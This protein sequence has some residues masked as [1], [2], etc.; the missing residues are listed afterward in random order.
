MPQPGDGLEIVAG[1]GF[2]GWSTLNDV[3]MGGRSSGWC[4][5]GSDG[6][7]MEAQVVAEGG[8]FVSCRSP[9]FVPPLD[10]SAYRGLALELDGDGRR[11]KLAIACADRVTG[12]AELIPGGL[13]WVAEFGTEPSGTT[14]VVLPF[15]RLTASVRA[16]PLGLPLRFDPRRIRRLQ[17]LH[18]RFNDSGGPNPGF[19]AGP[20]RLV[21]RRI[22]AVA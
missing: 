11:Y 3:I 21:I 20:L 8:G 14:R 13:R 2:S 12:A 10:L 6:L 22:E 5:A 9:D 19:R 15:Q 7:V 17:I 16:R 1:A 18:S 4:S